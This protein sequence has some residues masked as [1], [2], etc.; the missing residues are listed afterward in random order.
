M[1][2]ISKFIF[3]KAV[4]AYLPQDVIY[5]KK[6]GFGVPLDHWFRHELKELAYDTLLS[7]T[8]MQRGYFRREYIEFMLIAI[9]LENP[10]ST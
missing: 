2:I 9:K 7:Q 1:R 10:G 4:E 8:A 3:K 6:M 5:R